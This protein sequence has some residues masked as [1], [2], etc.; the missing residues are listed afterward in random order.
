[1]ANNRL[2]RELTSQPLVNANVGLR[3]AGAAGRTRPPASRRRPPARRQRGVH[4]PDREGEARRP[5]PAPVEGARAL[6]D[7]HRGVHGV[8]GRDAGGRFTR[9]AARRAAPALAVHHQRGSGAALRRAEGGVDHRRS[10]Q[11]VQEY[12]RA[13]R[14]A[15]GGD[16]PLGARR[17]RVAPR[18]G[19]PLRLLTV[20]RGGGVSP[21]ERQLVRAAGRAR[22]GAASLRRV[23]ATADQRAALGGAHRQLRREGGDV[24][25]QRQRH[26]PLR[27]RSAGC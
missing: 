2:T 7:P 20:R 4:E 27:R 23:G 3:F 21:G 22:R 6:R 9:Q 16:A 19:A 10:L 12:A 26:P 11:H 17:R 18:G 24:G 13:A 15:A 1:M 5:A 8:A 14:P 25:R